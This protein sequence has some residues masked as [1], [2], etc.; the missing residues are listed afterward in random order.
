MRVSKRHQLGVVGRNIGQPGWI[1]CRVRI[2][3][4]H[5]DHGQLRIAECFGH[6][7]IVEIRDDAVAFEAFDAI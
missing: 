3:R 2:R 5:R 1:T 6:R 4:T 7:R